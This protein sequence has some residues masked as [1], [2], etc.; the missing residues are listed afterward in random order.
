MMLRQRTQAL[1]GAVPVERG[2][3]GDVHTPLRD[4]APA[5]ARRG[6]ALRTRVKLLAV[7]L[8][9]GSTALLARAFDL[10]VVRKAFYQ[11]Q[12]EARFLRDL[13]IPVSRGTITDH[14]GEALAISTPVE[15]IWA[16]PAE[17]L[18]A[19]ERIPELARALGLDAK[20]LEKRLDERAEREFYYLKRHLAPDQ[21]AE[22]LAL[23]IPG[24]N[25]QREFKRFY[26]GGEVTA[27][28]LGSTNLDDHGQE[29]LELAFDDWLSG[30]PGLK[31]VI[32][33]RLGHIV[34]DVEL[35]KEPQPGRELRL[36]IDR[37]IQYLAYRELKSAM[38]ENGAQSGS[39]VILDAPTGEVLA[40]VNWPS[41]N[42]NARAGSDPS[43]RRN[44]AVTDLFEPGSVA[45]AFTIAAALESGKFKADTLIDTTP[46]TFPVA[47]H[48]V[49]DVHNYGVVDL[50][51]LL[52]KSSN[53]GA[54]KIS[55]QLSNEHLY[56]V[57]RRFGFGQPTGSGFPGEA[58]GV[59]NPGKS[60]GILEKVTASYGYGF[61][62]TPLQVAQ[63]YAALADNGRLRPPTFVAGGKSADSALLDPEIARS[64]LAMLESVVGPSGTASKAAVPNYRVAGKTG[65]S[66]K[67]VPGGYQ[68]R[69]I[70]VFAGVVPA[71]NPRLVG[72]VVI[73]DPRGKNYYGGLVAAPVFGHVM[74]GALRLLNVAPDRLEVQFAGT[75]VEV[76]APLLD[77][78]PVEA[79]SVEPFADAG[80]AP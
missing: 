76:T 45:K 21:A 77:D 25:A 40:M 41:Y 1:R 35:L 62:A 26:P 49:R 14:N 11:E 44:R 15:S 42:P 6:S 23:G 13:A 8:L 3:P 29:G 17:V 58:T 28:V 51:K 53:V 39:F 34:E 80:A 72:V 22:V 5:Q 4:R 31:R 32:K 64:V 30:A 48:I 65:T 60:W 37:R 75:P 70:S 57:F 79:E 20:D 12:G 19:R 71:T 2:G 38:A 18:A 68:S 61:S 9:L 69:Y 63:A 74:P 54:A 33:D 66:R 73:D 78:E 50:T 56:D 59:L 43:V 27:H 47:N 67:A 7:V 10:Q 46:G 55:L 24:V 16:Q 52:Q 36:S